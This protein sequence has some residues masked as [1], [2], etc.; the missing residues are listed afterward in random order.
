MR[1]S[2]AQP[3]R[4]QVVDR[5]LDEGAAAAAEIDDPAL[6]VG[7]AAADRAPLL[8]RSTEHSGDRGAQLL[9]HRGLHPSPR[10]VD[11]DGGGSTLPTTSTPR[12]VRALIDSGKAEPALVETAS[13][14]LTSP[15]DRG[16]TGK[17]KQGL[18]T[19]NRLSTGP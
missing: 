3:R 15:Q 19:E 9:V 17:L 14:S 11:W 6:V 18:G 5:C 16:C 2:I 10:T 13:C 8:R 12:A 1:C 7:V 4:A